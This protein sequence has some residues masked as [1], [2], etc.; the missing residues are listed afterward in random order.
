MRHPRRRIAQVVVLAIVVVASTALMAALD[1][2]G[3]QAP[4]PGAGVPAA[5]VASCDR[6]N[7]AKPGDARPV[8]KPA[9]E[10]DSVKPVAACRMAPQCST[11][12]DCDVICGAGHGKCVHSNCP[13]RICRCR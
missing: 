10:V 1:A 4:D 5:G 8:V 9:L 6:G 11:D 7:E 13:V 2:T 3:R 12:S